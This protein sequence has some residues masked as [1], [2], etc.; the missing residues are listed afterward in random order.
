MFNKKKYKHEY[1]LRLIACYRTHFKEGKLMP[2]SLLIL[3][4]AAK[5]DLDDNNT[6]IKDWEY[7]KH[8]HEGAWSLKVLS[9][10]KRYTCLSRQVKWL[11]FS[12]LM[13]VYDTL[14]NY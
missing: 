6:T 13:T 14:V 8:V 7:V 12:H 9:W 1:F 3:I 5:R 4:D 11:T 2:S 10:S